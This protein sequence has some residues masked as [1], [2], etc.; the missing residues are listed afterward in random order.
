MKGIIQ[1][2]MLL[3]TYAWVEFFLGTEKGAVVKRI[4]EKEKCFT[5]IVSIAEIIHWCLRNNLEETNFINVV[6]RL[7]VVLNLN[8]E[9]VVFGG[10]IN[11]HNKIKIKN[12]GMIDSL[13]YSTARFYNL[14][15]LTGDSHFK[16]LE[17]TEML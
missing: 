4:L 13:I 10:K 15:V 14:I 12:W 5:S 17:G 1:I 3:D 6:E 11:F 9:I 2:E 16:N 7:S 8:K